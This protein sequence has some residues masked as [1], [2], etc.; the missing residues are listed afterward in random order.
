MKFLSYPRRLFLESNPIPV[1]KV[2]ELM[3]KIG[4]GIRPPL[5]TFDLNLLDKLR[6]AMMIG[7][8]I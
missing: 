1:K 8:C 6:E 4:P 5:T 3:G 7:K 2:L